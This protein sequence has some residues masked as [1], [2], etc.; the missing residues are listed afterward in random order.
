MQELFKNQTKYSEEEYNLFLESYNK[1]YGL[2]DI[3]YSLINIAFFTL[4]TIYAILNKEVV[5]SI[6]LI[7]GILTYIWYKFIRPRRKVDEEKQSNKIQKEF[8][9]TF[10]F[11]PKY[12]KVE[13]P[14]GQA[15][16][17]YF[18]LYKVIETKSVRKEEKGRS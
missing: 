15:Q 16:K 4:C 10:Y 5:L 9:N 11:Y 12:F 17:T 6:A 18:G 1:E 13:N 8:I 2:S 14:E 3:L 7:I